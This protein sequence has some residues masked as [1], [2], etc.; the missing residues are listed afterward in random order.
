MFIYKVGFIENIGVDTIS[1]NVCVPC[2]VVISICGRLFSSCPFISSISCVYP[3][4]DSSRGGRFG[5]CHH[6]LVHLNDPASSSLENL[7]LTCACA[8]FSFSC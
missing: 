2:H 7:G 5:P 3:C 6:L 8:I 1:H 4:C